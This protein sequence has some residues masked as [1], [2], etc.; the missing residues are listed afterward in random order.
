MENLK[1]LGNSTTL[2]VT[3]RASKIRKYLELKEEAIWDTT[4]AVFRG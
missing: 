3:I 4:I 1:T 2:M